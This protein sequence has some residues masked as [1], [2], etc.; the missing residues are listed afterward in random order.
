MTVYLQKTLKSFR[1]FFFH[2]QC[3]V[4]QH[5]VQVSLIGLLV[6]P[7]RTAH[8]VSL[9]ITNSLSLLKLMF[10]KSVIPSNHL[11][12]CHPLL[13]LPSIF[14]SIRI[15]SNESV[16]NIS[17]PKYWSFSFSINLPNDY[18]GL[19]C[20][21]FDCFDLLAVQGTLKS[22]IQH[23]NSKSIDSSALRFPY[24][25]TLTSIQDY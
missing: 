10:I 19:I 12:L 4:A 13:L 16:L 15:F 22:L 23:H 14:P 17:W 9:S 25:S 1:N 20:F 3:N 6:T 8:Q 24:S 7:W 11:I 18:S 21:Q 5:S 2:F